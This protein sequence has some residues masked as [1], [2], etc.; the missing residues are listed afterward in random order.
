MTRVP[1]PFQGE[2]RRHA[3]PVATYG[4]PA[5]FVTTIHIDTRIRRAARSKT[6][7]RAVSV[8]YTAIFDHRVTGYGDVLWPGDLSDLRD[9]WDGH[10]GA[11]DSDHWRDSTYWKSWVG[12][13]TPAT[14]QRTVSIELGLSRIKTNVP[15]EQH[16]SKSV[17]DAQS[18]EL[19]SMDN[20]SRY[21]MAAR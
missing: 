9:R 19:N 8:R 2:L 6:W 16:H 4:L 17:D 12:R 14:R 13:V 18:V 21:S 20:S 15:R 1:K 11:H 10:V 5:A 7:A 3:F